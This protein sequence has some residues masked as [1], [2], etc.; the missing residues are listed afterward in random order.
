MNGSINDWLG[1]RTDFSGHYSTGSGIDVK[2]HTFAFGPQL[3]YRRHD[4]VV[5]FFHALFGG[6]WASADF[7]D[8][9]YSDAAFVANIGGGMDWTAHKNCA[10]RVIQLD[11]LLTRF[12]PH[13]SFDPRISAGIVFRLGSK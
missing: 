13:T 6:G 1:I 11:S 4:K 5:P 12:G 10:V 2:L 3:S 8:I 9:E 7:Q